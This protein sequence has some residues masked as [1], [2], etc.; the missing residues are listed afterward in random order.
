MALR[1]F[2]AWQIVSSCSSSAS[3][4]NF[5]RDLS[6]LREAFN[7]AH[8]PRGAHSFERVCV[9]STDSPVLHRRFEI[10]AIG[11]PSLVARTWFTVG[12]HGHE[13]NRSRATV[14]GGH[15]A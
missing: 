5:S 8:N 3:V 2:E 9:W 4:R 6:L 15:R 1:F 14:H 7:D 11:G 13:C 10:S 12:C